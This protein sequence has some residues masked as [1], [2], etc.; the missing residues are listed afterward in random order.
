ML[1]DFINS[2]RQSMLFSLFSYDFNH[3]TECSVNS[4]KY[5]HKC[6]ELMQAISLS[7]VISTH[8]TV[9]PNQ[10]YKVTPEAIDFKS[11][12]KTSLSNSVYFYRPICDKITNLVCCYSKKH[13]KKHYFDIAISTL[14]YLPLLWPSLPFEVEQ[15]NLASHP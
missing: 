4:C 2:I 7:F 11:I 10:K 14:T 9:F 8:L 3:L 6:F 1:K 13:F 5:R 12:E 15:L